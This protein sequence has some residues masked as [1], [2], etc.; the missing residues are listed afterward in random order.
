MACS[1]RDFV[2][3][4]TL[5]ADYGVKSMVH[6]QPGFGK[7]PIA[8]TA[9]LPIMLVCE[10]G[11]L[12]LRRSN[13]QA[14]PAFTVDRIDDFFNWLKNSNE[15]RNYHTCVIDSVSEMASIY[16]R[17]EEAKRIHGLQA[18]GNMAEKVY[19]HLHDLFLKKYIHTYLIA[20]QGLFDIGGGAMQRR[21][22]FP[23]KELNVLIPHMYDLILH[24]EEAVAPG[25]VG[26]PIMF[27]TRGN[28]SVVARD[29]SGKLNEYEPCDL[30]AMFA[31]CM[32]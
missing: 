18:Y 8:A 24:L 2:P 17:A 14:Y 21:P 23:G 1:Q 27:R 13:V 11:T 28:S 29:R 3:V 30:A 19:N 10:P 6:S 9:P 31:K 15:V 25:I 5:S 32:S 16:L 20:K 26:N 4:S 12:S 22:Y 7:T